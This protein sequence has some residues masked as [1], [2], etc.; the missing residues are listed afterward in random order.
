MGLMIETSETL[1]NTSIQIKSI[2][3][4]LDID[5]IESTIEELQDQNELGRELQEIISN[6]LNHEFNEESLYLIKCIMMYCFFSSTYTLR[7]VF[8]FFEQKRHLDDIFSVIDI[9]HWLFS[10]VRIL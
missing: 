6:P 4:N 5:K 1:K 10:N 9:H 7:C 8:M 2:N 3:N